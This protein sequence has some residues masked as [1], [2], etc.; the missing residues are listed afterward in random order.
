MKKLLLVVVL[1]ISTANIW[2]QEDVSGNSF[3]V[4]KNI[5]IYNALFNEVNKYYVDPIQPGKMV[6]KS[7]DAMLKDLDPYTNYITEED[8]EDYRFQTTGKYGG[9][10]CSL[11]DLGD[12]VAID[13]VMENGPAAKAGLKAGDFVIEIENKSAKNLD[14]DAIRKLIKGSPGTIVKFKIK[15]AITGAVTNKTITR[16]EINVNNIPF[17]GLVGK[18]KDI[19]MVRLSQ[20]TERASNNIKNALDSLKRANNNLKG[21]I[22]DLRY[23]PGGILDEA[24]DI[25]NLFLNREQL[26]VAT[27]GKVE[28]WNKNYKTRNLPWDEKI[29]VVILING[30]SASASEIVSGTLQDVDRAVIVGQ[31]SFGKGLVQTTRNLP[32]NAKVKVTT[33]KYYTPSGRCIQALDYS[34][35]NDD[36]S[37]GEI[38][39]SI[40]TLFKTKN[41]RSVYDGGGVE[42]D[43]KVKAN[44]AS[45]IAITLSNK[46]LL[47][48]YANKYVSEHTTIEQPATFILSD[49]DFDNF[50]KW[51]QAKD[52]TYNTKSMDAL[53]KVKAVAE[54]ENYFEGIK[55]EYESL[56]KALNQDKEKDIQKNKKEIKKLLQAE[57]VSRYYY[58]RGATLNSMNE[59]QELNEAIDIIYDNARYEK[60]LSGK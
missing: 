8:I 38:A 14:E 53:D 60:I 32:F 23:N 30:N 25:C 41:G 39:D 17:S 59:D 55:A 31:K 2:A 50:S 10:G 13:D 24:V 51:L 1:A 6:K 57:I 49:M 58:S 3:E 44:D 45:K 15:D 46:H 29:P 27:K 12:F 11:R 35:R 47:F 43:V 19:A 33:A 4:S 9:V 16:E 20:F 22:I 7:L 40:K 42:P 52:Y 28:E 34:H 26:V 54:K 5:E 56:K 21:V 18:N 48:E 37:V 36:G